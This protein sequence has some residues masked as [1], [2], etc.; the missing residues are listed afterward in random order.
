MRK[1]KIGMLMLTLMTLFLVGCSSS[2]AEVLKTNWDFT[3]PKSANC[4]EIYKNSESGFH[5]DGYRY[6]V[7]SYED[8]GEGEITALFSWTVTEQKMIFHSD[9]KQAIGEWL[10]SL[11]VPEKEY[12][13]YTDCKYHYQS[14]NDLSEIVIVW[15]ATQNK[16]Y[17]AESFL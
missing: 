15:N 4:K 17:I 3:L 5:G 1:K 12:P 9:Y 7:Y 6:H 2:Y 11:E 8:E 14:Q 13:D 16:L 10:T